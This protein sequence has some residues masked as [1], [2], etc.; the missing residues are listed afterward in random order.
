MLYEAA[1]SK[2]DAKVSSMQS[3]GALESESESDGVGEESSNQPEPAA[4]AALPIPTTTV[5]KSATKPPEQPA[6]AASPTTTAM[7]L[8]PVAGHTDVSLPII[9]APLEAP[10]STAVVPSVRTSDAFVPDFTLGVPLGQPVPVPMAVLM[11]PATVVTSTKHY[12]VLYRTDLATVVT[13]QV[14]TEKG[15]LSLAVDSEPIFDEEY[16]VTRISSESP[17][18]RQLRRRGIVEVPIPSDAMLGLCERFDYDTNV[19]RFLEILIPRQKAKQFSLAAP[20]TQIL[21]PKKT[22]VPLLSKPDN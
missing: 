6:T 16:R 15:T 1:K 19:G 18:P 17:R 11:H 2:F 13:P 21:A 9:N 8:A 7:T 12:S 4:T 10:S 22:T 5:L 20:A 14:N 3:A